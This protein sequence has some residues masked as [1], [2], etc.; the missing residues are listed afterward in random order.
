M[1]RFARCAHCQNLANH[2]HLQDPG[3]DFPDFQDFGEEHPF[4]RPRL[5]SS[6]RIATCCQSDFNL[7]QVFPTNMVLRSGLFLP[8]FLSFLSLL[9]QNSRLQY[10][11]VLA[12]CEVLRIYILEK[13]STH[14]SASRQ[15]RMIL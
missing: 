4:R 3:G 2:T 6:A 15:D 12:A 1:L 9:N 10:T 11:V 14:F 13:S 5:K 8:C 7:S